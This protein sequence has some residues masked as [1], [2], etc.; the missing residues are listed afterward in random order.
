MYNFRS[1]RRGLMEAYIHSKIP[2]MKESI[3]MRI[4][5]TDNFGGDYPDEKFVNLPFMTLPGAEKVAAVINSV[6]CAR[7]ESPRFWK[8]VENDY[9]LVPGFEP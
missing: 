2:S 3:K 7:D 4:V 9:K 1:A 8:V 6:C 5:E